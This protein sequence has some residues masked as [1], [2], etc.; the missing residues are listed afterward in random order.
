M[1]SLRWKLPRPPLNWS[2]VKQTQ[3]FVCPSSPRFY[4]LLLICHSP[5]CI[6]SP[7][8][9]PF[10]LFPL[11]LPSLIPS[12]GLPCPQ[13]GVSYPTSEDC[14]FLNVNTPSSWSPSLPLLPVMI[15]IHGGSFWGGSGNLNPSTLESNEMVFV[16]I[17]YRYSSFFFFFFG[18]IWGGRKRGR[19]WLANIT[20]LSLLSLLSPLSPL[21]LL[22]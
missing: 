13:P 3:T 15:W 21:I 6:L 9:P 1:G 11:L 18:V 2:G 10:P 7:P 4:P 20:H 14:L 12:Q 19:R 8:L 16:S 17:N 22:G 5:S